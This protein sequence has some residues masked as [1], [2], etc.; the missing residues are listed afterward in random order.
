MQSLSNLLP[1][2]YLKA[3]EEVHTSLACLVA[4]IQSLEQG[5]TVPFLARYRRRTTGGLDEER[6]RQLIERLE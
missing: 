6:L 5:T 4:V 1:S 2:E 3:A